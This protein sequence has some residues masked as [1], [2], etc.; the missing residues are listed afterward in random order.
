MSSSP[1]FDEAIALARKAYFAAIATGDAIAKPAFDAAAASFS[2]PAIADFAMAQ[3]RFNLRTS[4][5][6]LALTE[7]NDAVVIYAADESAD[8]AAVYAALAKRT[9]ALEASYEDLIEH[10]AAVDLCG[11]SSDLGAQ[12]HPD[13][14]DDMLDL[15]ENREILAAEIAQS[16]EWLLRE[17]ER[18]RSSSDGA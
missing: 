11:A 3:L 18:R 13:L 2:D 5:F 4:F 9:V 6:A 17:V 8:P 14:V 12:V 16:T 7:F 10:E 15:V 1:D